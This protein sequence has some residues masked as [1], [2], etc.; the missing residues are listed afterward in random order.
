MCTDKVPIPIGPCGSMCLS[1]KRKCLP[2][3]HEFGFIWPEV[4]HAKYNFSMMWK[5]GYKK[6]KYLEKTKKWYIHKNAISHHISSAGAQLQ[7]LPASKRPQPYVYGGSCRWGPTLPAC[8]PSSPPGGVSGPGVRTRSVYLVETN[9]KLYSSVRLW[10]WALSTRGQSF[11]RRM[12]GSVGCIVLPVN[13]SDR[14]DLSAGFTAFLLPWA[15][16]HLPVHVL[17]SIQCCIL[18]KLN[19]QHCP[20]EVNLFA[21]NEFKKKNA[22]KLADF[23]KNNASTFLPLQLIKTLLFSR[24]GW[25]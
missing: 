14:P 8:P 6:L 3:L 17:Q 9:W 4:S 23:S 2:V 18:G 21:K 7:P 22:P 13:H 5:I 11:H 16:H 10:Q 25:L 12:D 20:I 24:C 1:V 19:I 15:A